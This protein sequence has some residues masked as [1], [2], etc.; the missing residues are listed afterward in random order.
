MTPKLSLDRIYRPDTHTYKLFLR[1]F[2]PSLNPHIE[3]KRKDVAL[4]VI[5]SMK[6]YASW[7]DTHV[8]ELLNYGE[9][10]DFITSSRGRKRE[11]LPNSFFYSE[12]QSS[13][14]FQASN[15]K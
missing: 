9:K 6:R 11:I 4:A 2:E 14:G 5:D 3:A 8:S 1:L 7:I 13:Y 12:T 10:Q 15:G